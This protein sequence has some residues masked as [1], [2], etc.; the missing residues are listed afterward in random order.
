MLERNKKLSIIADISC[1]TSGYNPLPIYH[2]VTTHDKPTHQ[3]NINNHGLDILAIDNLPS[4]LPSESSTD[5]SAQLL[6]YLL[7]LLNFGT[8]V[9][10][11]IAKKI[12]ESRLG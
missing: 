12:F 7:Q 1:E 10:W 4:L 9:P 2:S 3:I 6:P 5:F 11:I 8:G